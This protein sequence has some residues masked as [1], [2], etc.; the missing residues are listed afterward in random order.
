MKYPAISSIEHDAKVA[1]HARTDPATA[2]AARR[3]HLQA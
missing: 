3:V 1:R 2:A